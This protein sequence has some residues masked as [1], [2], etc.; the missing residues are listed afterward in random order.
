MDIRLFYDE[1][2]DYSLPE[3]RDDQGDQ[4]IINLSGA[5][6]FVLLQDR[7]L[8]IKPSQNDVGIYPV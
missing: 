5:P 3:I 8:K 7:T 2:G 1:S 6:S 4:V